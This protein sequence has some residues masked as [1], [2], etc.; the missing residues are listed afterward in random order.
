MI[1]SVSLHYIYA[2]QEYFVPCYLWFMQHMVE[3]WYQ[4]KECIRPQIK[5]TKQNREQKWK[6]IL[7]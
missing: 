3:I 6:V 2:L 5:K 4:K 1:Q 7:A